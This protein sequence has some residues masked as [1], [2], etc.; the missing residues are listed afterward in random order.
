MSTSPRLAPTVD[1]DPSVL[2]SRVLNTTNGSEPPK[3]DN[4]FVTREENTSLKSQ[5]FTGG[6]NRISLL[7]WIILSITSARPRSTTTKSLKLDLCFWT[8]K[9]ITRQISPFLLSQMVLLQ[10]RYSTRMR[11]T[12]TT[13]NSLRTSPSMPKHHLFTATIVYGSRSLIFISGVT[14]HKINSLRGSTRPVK[15]NLCKWSNAP[16]IWVSWMFRSNTSCS[17]I[18]RNWVWPVSLK[19]SGKDK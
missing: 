10:T 1:W 12:T 14:E 13:S 15:Q 19:P 9:E 6:Q 16:T 17:L 18:L 8:T 2:P 5:C 3:M 7:S 11:P 4:S